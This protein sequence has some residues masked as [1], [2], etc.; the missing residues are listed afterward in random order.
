MLLT[1]GEGW[2]LVLVVALLTGPWLAAGCGKTARATAD[3]GDG[4]VVTGRL[5]FDV[6]AVLGSDGSTSLPATNDFTLVLDADARLAIAGG[7]GQGAVI[8]VTTADGRTFHSAGTF[9]VGSTG[10]VCTG[11]EDVRYDEFEVA[12]DGNS[13]SGSAR[14]SADISCG[15]CVFQVPFTA[16][17]IGT[18]DATPPSLRATGTNPQDPFEAFNLVTTEPLPASAT[19]RLVADDG[20]AI[21]LVPQTVDGP[22]PLVVGFAKPEVVLRDGRAYAVALD[23]LVDFAGQMD[24]SGTPLRLVSFPAAP[25]VPADG[26]ESVTETVLG[27]A[28]VMRA[29]P[30][31]AIAGNTSL[32]I[33]TT[34]AP[35][36]DPT[37]GHALMVRLSRQ[38]ADTK[39]VFSYRVVASGI[40][41]AFVGTI[42]VG[43][44]DASPGSAIDELNPPTGSPETLVVGGQM[45]I[46]T[47]VGVEEVPLPA[48]AT[49]EVLFFIAPS[50]PLCGNLAF[51]TGMGLLIDDLRLE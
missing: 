5:S 1:R 28:M 27:G 11:Q 50:N 21:D 15:D 13:L 45:A 31:P 18:S 6:V 38:P 17:L 44:E 39:L 48:D 20:T 51:P 23:G 16:T 36:L 9:S 34:G 25:L 26:F 19:A 42:R 12:I 10:S 43:S 22:I 40:E 37:A 4:P 24:R 14:G 47:P 49:S 2:S 32:Y 8:G 3:G 46:A 33:G 41:R 7:N 29:G 35:G 30:L